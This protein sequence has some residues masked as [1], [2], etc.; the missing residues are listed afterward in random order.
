M[1][2]YMCTSTWSNPDLTNVVGRARKHAGIRIRTPHAGLNFKVIRQKKS[3]NANQLI[4]SFHISRLDEIQFLFSYSFINSFQIKNMAQIRIIENQ[5]TILSSKLS[6]NLLFL[7]V[8]YRLI[9]TYNYS[10]VQ[11]ILVKAKPVF[12]ISKIGAVQ[13]CGIFDTC[14]LHVRRCIAAPF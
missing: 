3:A 11:C 12:R 8:I 7:S 9:V 6:M 13:Q 10:I 1:Y 4:N 5:R 2:M 14:R